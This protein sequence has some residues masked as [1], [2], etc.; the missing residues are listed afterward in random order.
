[1][2]SGPSYGVYISQLILKDMHDA[3]HIM[4]ILDIATIA[5]LI[6]LVSQGYIALRSLL[7]NFMAD[8]RIS[9]RNTRRQSSLW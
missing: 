7:R 2:P 5:W 9:L 1:M 4:M 3:A 6:A 8:I